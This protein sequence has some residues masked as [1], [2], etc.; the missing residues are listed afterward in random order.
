M[1][2]GEWRARPGRDSGMHRLPGSS[3]NSPNRCRNQPYIAQI[4]AA[5]YDTTRG[6]SLRCA[7]KPTRVS[8]IYRTEPTSKKWKTEKLKSKKRIC[9]E[10][11][12]NSPGNR[13]VNPEE[14]KED[15]DGK[16]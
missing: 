8:L 1:S 15:Y 5:C 2:R 12:V 14:E 3:T 11:S 13:G 16:D 10:V 7:R 6:A 9:S 4:Y